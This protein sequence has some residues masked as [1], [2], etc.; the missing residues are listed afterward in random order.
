MRPTPAQAKEILHRVAA[1]RGLGHVSGVR[2]SDGTAWGSC[3]HD[4]VPPR[5]RALSAE[6]WDRLPTVKWWGQGPY[7]RALKSGDYDKRT[8]TWRP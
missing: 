6:Q 3:R 4:D 1:Y 5:V 2:L 7:P 8:R